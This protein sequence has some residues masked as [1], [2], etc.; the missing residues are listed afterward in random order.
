MKLNLYELIPLKPKVCKVNV[1]KVSIVIGHLSLVICKGFNVFTYFYTVRLLTYLL[2]QLQEYFGN[3]TKPEFELMSYPTLTLPL[4]RGGN[5]RFNLPPFQGGTKGGS[6]KRATC[7]SRYRLAILVSLILVTE[8]FI[9]HSSALPLSPLSPEG[10]PSPPSPT[11]SLLT[12][13][14]DSG[15]PEYLDQ[16]LQAIKVGRVTDAIALFRKATELDPNLAPA[17]YNLGLA[18]RQIGQLQPAADAFYKATQADSKFALAYANLGGSLLEGSNLQQAGDYLRRAIEIDPKLGIAHY[19]LGLVY[20]QQRNWERAIP[21]FRKAMEFSPNAPEPA[22]HV[23][24]CYL[25]QGKT[26]KA[27]E[28]FRRAVKINP[29]YS[30]AHYNLGTILFSQ[31]KFKDALEAFR[32]AAEGNS[33]YANAY[34]GAGLA[35]IQLRQYSDAVKV[36]QYARDLYKAQGNSRWANQASQLLQQTQNLN[37]PQNFNYQPR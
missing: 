2:T 1:T 17:H 6:L 11:P 4:E 36:L 23:G 9:S 28:V 32:K 33:N 26:D 31:S 34:Y 7:I 30:E 15:A 13:Y 5:W 18:L 12:Q 16:G 25:Q 3:V 19:N 24:L 22:Y 21:S 20:E 10:V 35:F 37:N 14:V 29:K 27:K 8:S